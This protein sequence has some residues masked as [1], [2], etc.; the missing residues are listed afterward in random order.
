M[1]TEWIVTETSPYSGERPTVKTYRSVEEAREAV[2]HEICELLVDEDAPVAEGDQVGRT[3]EASEPRSGRKSPRPRFDPRDVY[4]PDE[5]NARIGDEVI[6]KIEPHETPT[7]KE[8]TMNELKREVRDIIDNYDP[9]ADF[10]DT[11]LKLASVGYRMEE[12][13]ARA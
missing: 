10:E 13:M 8:T 6:W 4:W 11:I 9:D 5:N 3:S 1:K 7:R 2:E 12:A